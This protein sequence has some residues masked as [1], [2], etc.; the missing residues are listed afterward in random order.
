MGEQFGILD[1]LIFAGVALFL[2]YRLGTVLGKRTGHQNPTEV[3]GARSD[4]SDGPE[5]DDDDTVVQLPK[6]R[7]EP[8]PIDDEMLE[9][10]LGPGL[11]QIKLADPMFDPD[12]FL[13]GAKVAF[14][15][16][17]D[18]FSQGDVKTLR[19]LLNDDVYDNFY[20][21]IQ[22]REA[23]NQRLEETL[24]G[25]DSAE[26]IEAGMED[27]NA[28]VTVKFVSQQVDA[29]YDADG[30]VIEGNPNEVVTVT[31][32]WTFERN[33]RDRDPNWALIE[34]RSPN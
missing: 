18:S 22:A 15:M 7:P 25:I 5:D 9:G 20:N 24:V 16:V 28:R 29:L 23:A 26:I 17:L 11:T 19:N 14:E 3:Y 2:I 10:P 1:I 4:K 27:S 33:T 30:Q 31:D 12:Q 6:S 34:T 8:K 21:A 32:I 13:D